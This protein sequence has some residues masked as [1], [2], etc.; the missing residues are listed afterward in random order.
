MFPGHTLLN[1][2]HPDSTRLRCSREAGTRAAGRRMRGGGQGRA[3]V[4]LAV[5]Q[6]WAQ[7]HLTTVHSPGALFQGHL[8]HVSFHLPDSKPL[9]YISIYQSNGPHWRQEQ[10]RIFGYIQSVIEK[11]NALGHEIL[12]AGD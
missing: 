10:R 2:A 3:G 1:S 11:G 6:Q 9:D 8:I 4:L 5:S 7:P 12:L